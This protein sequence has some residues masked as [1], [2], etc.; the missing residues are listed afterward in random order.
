MLPLKIFAPTVLSCQVEEY[1]AVLRSCANSS[2]R[3]WFLEQASQRFCPETLHNIH[4]R[5]LTMITPT[6]AVKTEADTHNIDDLVECQCLAPATA[7]HQ[8]NRFFREFISAD[9]FEDAARLYGT[10]KKPVPGARQSLDDREFS[11]WCAF[12]K[13]RSK[14]GDLER[15]LTKRPRETGVPA[16][17]SE[18][19]QVRLDEIQYGSFKD[20]LTS[21]MNTRDAFFAIA[22]SSVLNV[23]QFES[24]WMRFEDEATLDEELAQFRTMCLPDLVMRFYNACESMGPESAG[25]CLDVCVAIATERYHAYEAFDRDHMMHLLQ[26]SRNAYLQHVMIVG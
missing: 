22:R 2:T 13:A 10:F 23:I 3:N 25:T 26:A 15:F 4:Q 1:A 11:G 12:V 24:G 20:Q 9:R 7:L 21:W 8:A 5:L 19:V 14:I 16:S 18:A 17:E 6:A